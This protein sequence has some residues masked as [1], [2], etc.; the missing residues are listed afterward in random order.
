MYL[1]CAA[2]GEA[3]HN[4]QV[5]T[6]GDSFTGA[7]HDPADAVAF[8][9]NLQLAMLHANWPAKLSEHPSS[10]EIASPQLPG[11]PVDTPHVFRG[12]RVRAAVHCGIPTG[13][14]VGYWQDDLDDQS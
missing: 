1:N 6:E 13:I 4:M 8:A 2:N 9:V 7:F 12:L 3:V 11:H 5:Y 10:S 14:E